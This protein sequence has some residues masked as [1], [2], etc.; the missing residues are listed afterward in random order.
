MTETPENVGSDTAPSLDELAQRL[1]DLW[2]EQL[3]AAA[4][5]PD[6]AGQAA[7]LMAAMPLP[8]MWLNQMG[9]MGG[10]SAP[11]FGNM[12]GISPLAGADIAKAWAQLASNWMQPAKTG[13]ESDG[14]QQPGTAKTARS[15]APGATPAS[16]ASQPGGLDMDEL[17]TRL[18]GLEKRL[19]ELA[20]KPKRKPAAKRRSKPVGSGHGPIGAADPKRGS[21]PPDDGAA[22]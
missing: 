2:Q 13:G 8:G 18:A 1:L 7:R 22:G 21:A 10:Q 19:G 3:T 12:P 17:R 16:A 20:T 9:Q 15:S 5:N 11:G 14:S 6:L 4:A